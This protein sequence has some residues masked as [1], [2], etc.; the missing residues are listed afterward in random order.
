MDEGIT[1]QIANYVI[2]YVELNAWRV[3]TSC[4]TTR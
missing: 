1:N 3:A 2:N 4:A